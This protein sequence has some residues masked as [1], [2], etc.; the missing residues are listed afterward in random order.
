MGIK[1]VEATNIMLASHTEATIIAVKWNDKGNCI[2]ISHPDFTAMDL[3]PFGNTI[4]AAITG[5]N[6][7]ECT[8][9][10]DKKWHCIILNGVDTG[11]TD[12]N[13]DIE[14]T[15]FQGHRPEEILKE[16][17][18]N[19]PSLATTTIMEAR[20]LTC[21]ENLRE[22]AHSSVILTV[23]SQEDVDILL[24][25]VR[26][27]VMY[28]RLASFTRYQDMKPVKQCMVCWSYSHLKCN[29]D[30][31]CRSC[32]GEHTETD[33]TC[34]ECPTSEDNCKNCNHLPTKCANCKG[35]HP[36]DDTKC[37]SRMAATGTTHTPPKGS[38]FLHSN[39]TSNINRDTPST[40]SL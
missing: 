26:R 18:T 16:L 40:T 3:V 17:Q 2:A 24:H 22:K 36:A 8:T 11:K 9:T 19:N 37:P 5:Q 29:K 21:P 1:A 28:G 38:H 39:P 34:L 25:H 32:A 7:I 12:I 33:H 15:Q 31:K 10:L 14:L 35:P 30:P 13:E 6:N 20:W 4:A 27:V 23:S